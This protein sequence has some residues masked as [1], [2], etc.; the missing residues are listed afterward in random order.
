MQVLIK[1]AFIARFR[2]CYY[3]LKRTLNKTQ[4]TLVQCSAKSLQG[5]H[6]KLKGFCPL[7][8]VK[9]ETEKG[10]HR[11][12]VLCSAGIWDLF[13]LTGTF[14]SDHPALKSRWG[15]A[16]SRWMQNR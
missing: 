11:N 6:R 10:L 1:S 9:T 2:S 15:D 16:N 5:L 14:S 4:M 13:V 3:A 8:E 7:N 12:L